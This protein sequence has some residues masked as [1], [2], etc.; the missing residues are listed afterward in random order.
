MKHLT[1]TWARWNARFEQRLADLYRDKDEPQTILFE[2]M[3]YSLL[4]G[5]KRLRPFLVYAFC[6]ACGGSPEQADSAAL[7]IEMIHTYSLIHDDLPCM[8]NDDYRRGKLT[9]HKVYG[10]NLAVLAGDGL[11]TDAFR[12]LTAGAI[13]ADAAAACVQVLSV[14]AGPFGMVGGQVLDVLS[15]QRRCTEREVL[16]IQCRKTGGLI[17][18]ACEMGVICAGGDAARQEAA[19]QYAEHL[20]L[21]FQIRDDILDVIGD[22]ALLG[23]AVGVDG[24]KNTFV[25]LYGVDRCQELVR[26]ETELAVSALSVFQNAELLRDLAEA[27]AAREY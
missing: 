11:L 3:R 19:R 21:A 4:A 20:G 13:P 6:Q 7:A 24:E 27:L 8:D 16:D 17:R 9:N 15:E 23:K 2:A 18:A 5:G 14:N 10:E 26:K 12:V 22:A 25:R 1:E